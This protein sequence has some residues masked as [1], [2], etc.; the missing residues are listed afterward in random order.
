MGNENVNMERI[1]CIFCGVSSNHIAI[2]ENGYNGLKCETCNIIY[3]SP[4]P[5][6]DYITHLYTDYQS[7]QYADAQFQ[8]DRYKRMEAAR[9][10]LKIRNYRESG[11]ILEIGP[12]GGFFLLEARNYNYEPYGIELNPFEARWIKEKFHIPCETTAL[13]KSS[14]G[15]RMF[16][17]IYHRDVLSHMYDPVGVFGDIN[18]SLK[19]KGLLVF[20]TGNFAD[21]KEKYYKFYSQFFY[22]DHLFFFGE[23]SVEILL[24]KTGF[25][26]VHIYKDAIFLKL[27]LQKLL[28]RLRDPLKDEKIVEDMRSEMDQNTAVERQSSGKRRLRLAYRYVSYYLTL[29]G[30]ILPKN[31][32]P[33]NFLVIAE[34]ISD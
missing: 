3:I 13:S 8:F 18:Q 29:L 27:L 31:G 10:L 12:G 16:D 25:K 15:G 6:A 1:N 4:R 20:E 21:V 30:V 24:K 32:R 7:V 9:T 22:P 34:K 28:W 23:K 17:I 14:F 5:S 33:L 26:C 2:S 11:S 19:K